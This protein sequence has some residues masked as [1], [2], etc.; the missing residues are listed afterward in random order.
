MQQVGLTYAHTL[1]SA[2]LI[3]IPLYVGVFT[4]H[5]GISLYSKV[6]ISGFAVFFVIPLFP[7]GK[8]HAYR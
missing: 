3:N 4:I 2:Y 8:H 1:S 5:Y 6:Y 7:D